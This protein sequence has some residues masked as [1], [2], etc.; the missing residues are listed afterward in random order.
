MNW[1]L[2]TVA[3]A[4]GGGR[5]GA[6]T[7]TAVATDS[8]RVAPG[9]LFVALRGER[10]DGHE[11]VN[12][13]MAAG[14]SAALVETGRLPAGVPGVEVEDTLSAL[15][16]LA[17]FH[18]RSI[19]APVVAITG[20]SGKTTTKDMTAAALGPGTHAATRSYNNEVGVP[21][22]LL[23]A[24]EGATAVVV[25]VGSRGVGHIAALA[26][27]IGHRVAVITNVGPAHL[28]TFGD[29][30]TV[31]RA[32]WELVEALDR[33][34]VAVLPV[35]AP[36][37]H[38]ASGP[39]ITFGEDAAADV[40]VHGVELDR[41]GRPSFTVSHHGRATAVTL[42]LAGRHQALNA[43]AAIGAALALEVGLEEAAGRLAATTPS[44]WRMEV[45]ERK[46]DAG[47]VVVVNDAYNANP[48]SM[49]SALRTV[50]A[51]PG[52]HL[53]VLGR[54]L[55]LGAGEAEFHR[56]IGREARSL[57][58]AAV[59]IVG[60]DPGIAEGFGQGAV[61]AADPEQGR[62]ELDRLL[63][64]GDVV[65]VKASRAVGLEQMA[66]AIGRDRPR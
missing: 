39:V 16:A 9:S 44:P 42:P 31:A 29:L 18:R 49:Q 3:A 22:T 50:A 1:D 5:R 38:R 62:R 60:E 35:E 13:A 48:D 58:Y 41:W 4:V 57:G 36:L 61:S 59:I 45:V 15:G 46:T 30:D 40:A 11:F 2:S 64:P 47:L 53:A 63:R 26:P 54:M 8:R 19:Q 55:E 7:V 51:M 17:G 43:A 21:L 28:E 65:L 14:A 27:L 25:E 56:Q 66:D 32:K 6:A 24:P 20:S 34:G 33:S 37:P 10:F 12:Q 52:R 23:E